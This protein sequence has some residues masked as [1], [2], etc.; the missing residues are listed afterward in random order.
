MIGEAKLT[1]HGYCRDVRSHPHARGPRGCVERANDR[2]QQGPTIKR[3]IAADAHGKPI[4]AGETRTIKI[5]LFAYCIT[6]KAN[7]AETIRAH[8]RHDPSDAW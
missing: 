1:K 7:N 4:H 5:G 8:A 6:E 3:H 2:S